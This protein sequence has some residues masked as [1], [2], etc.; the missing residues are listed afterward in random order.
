VSTGMW[1]G[2]GV[3]SSQGVASLVQE[4]SEASNDLIVDPCVGF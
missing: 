3:N 1:S 4:A 2:D